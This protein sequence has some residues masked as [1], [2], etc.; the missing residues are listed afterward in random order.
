MWGDLH[1][2]L[3]GF[4]R[5][6][7]SIAIVVLSLAAG[8]GANALLYHVMDA[9]LFR[10]P[11]GVADPGDLVQ[12][13]TS[14]FNG[15]AHGYSSYPD[16]LS[17]RSG[18]AAFSSLAAFDDS[19][20]AGVRLGQSLQRVRIAAVSDGFFAVLG[21]TAFAGRLLTAED[22]T[23][24]SRPRAAVISFRLWTLFDRPADAVGR[25]MTIEGEDFTIVGIAPERFNGLQLARTC[26][27]WIPLAAEP[28]S[29]S[30]GDRR[31]SIVG[32]LRDGAALDSAGAEALRIS[33]TLAEAY[34]ETNRGTRS[35]DEEPRVMTVAG[36][37]WI[38]PASRQRTILIGAVVLGAS[39]LLLVSACVNAATLLLFRSA[40]RR[41]ELAVKVAL[42]AT[43]RQL[44][45]QAA[46]ESLSIS[47]GGAA[48]GLLLA[49]WTAAAL[50]ALFAPEQAEML[51]LT[52]DPVLVFGAILLACGAG[53]L[54][55]I[56]PAWHVMDTVDAD[57]LRSDVGGIS[58]R[59]G[60][61]PVRAAVIVSQ[62][63]LSTVLLVA[64]GILIRTLAVALDGDL[65]PAGR[66]V[67]IAVLRM[68]G[69]LA[70]NALE[71][72]TFQSGAVQA[73]RKLEG[74]KALGWIATL[75]V[76]RSA[77]RDFRIETGPGVTESLQVDVNVVSP[78]YFSVLRIP[79]IEGRNFTAD[80]T[81][82]ARPVVIVNDLLAQRY[83]FPQAMGRR[84]LDADG[85]ELEIVGVVRSG[86]YR[87]L[88]EPPEPTVYFPLSQQDYRGPIHLA[89][90]T[91]RDAETL[92]EPLHATL[93]SLG[94]V[95]VRMMTFDD[96][97]AEAL[98]L[99]RLATTLVASCAAWAL[100]LATIG[101]Y[102]IVADAVRGRTPEIGLRI[103]LGA[104][105]LQVLRL[106]FGEGLHL[107]VVGVVAGIGAAL[108][109]QRLAAVFVHALPGLDVVSF[110][111]VPLAV[112]IVMAGAAALPARRA[113]R[114]SPTIALRA[115]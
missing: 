106:V 41:R 78:S 65:G 115:E 43:R 29:Q 87:T 59:A 114:I 35:A 26:D 39:G 79:V 22:G 1:Y 73:V 96:H 4:A 80:D 62:V 109:L 6:K 53:I 112:T 108:L 64:A 38:D 58:E 23:P 11:A 70:G 36:Y 55:A 75:P 101:V 84:L 71:G 25:G 74:V 27:V 33:N 86:R 13:F 68:P 28:V 72:L 15:A 24:A 100:V 44:V 21:T 89:V 110:V 49:R 2:A 67:A 113:I 111:G 40:A 105:A 102:G 42:G 52:L 60:S 31:L 8:T 81:P 77:T 56:G 107:T 66:G 10:G 19:A 83:F 14:K 103:A 91:D 57:V 12:V 97:L 82:R 48:L 46:V 69:D 47:L 63:G 104:G 61:R 54:F 99:D 95:Q 7:T 98:T 94:A 32:R 85:T 93:E 92:L 20:Q 17:L 9:L 88:Q 51:D 3:R 34:P 76:G 18:S 16:F 5:A 90:R 30:R 37:S 50:P 45:R